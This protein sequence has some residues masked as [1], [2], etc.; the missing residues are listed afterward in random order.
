MKD[1]IDLVSMRK[2]QVLPSELY[3]VLDVPFSMSGSGVDN[4]TGDL[5]D[6]RQRS[7]LSS[8][9]RHED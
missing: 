2:A 4:M 3:S 9:D 8:L 5:N 6:C 1:R 7:S